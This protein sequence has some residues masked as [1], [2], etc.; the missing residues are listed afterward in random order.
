MLFSTIKH[1]AARRL[2]LRILPSFLMLVFAAALSAA[3]AAEMD[4]SLAQAQ[5]FALERS[6]LFSAKGYGVSASRE[7]AVAAGQLP[8]PNF[9]VGIDNLPVNGSDRFS[10]SN[11]F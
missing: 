1:L 6:R 7:M 9:K 11:D 3:I 8:D 10:L 5:Q 2:V 4:L